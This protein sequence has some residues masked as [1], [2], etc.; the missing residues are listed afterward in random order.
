MSSGCRWDA[1]LLG[2]W[3]L[4]LVLLRLFDYEGTYSNRLVRE[5]WIGDEV[6]PVPWAR[7]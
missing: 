2:M 7:K 5:G 6:Q 1:W 4:E 3:Y